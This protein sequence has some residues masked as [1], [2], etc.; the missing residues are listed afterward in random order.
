MFAIYC[1]DDN[2]R[3][4]VTGQYVYQGNV[5]VSTAKLDDE[6]VGRIKLYKSRKRAENGI[7]SYENVYKDKFEVK[8]LAEEEVQLITDTKKILTEKRF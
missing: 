5:F 7:R 1:N 3:G 4:F 8:E 6:T 2:L